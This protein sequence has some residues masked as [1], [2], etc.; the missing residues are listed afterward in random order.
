MSLIYVL[1]VTVGAYI[2]WNQLS[3]FIRRDADCYFGIL[4]F[5][6]RH[7]LYGEWKRKN[8]SERPQRIIAYPSQSTC[9]LPNVISL[10]LDKAINN[11]VHWPFL[12]QATYYSI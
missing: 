6:F 7:F 11:D 5:E 9:N 3:I 4:I 12:Q 10:K 1:A 2:Q 8:I